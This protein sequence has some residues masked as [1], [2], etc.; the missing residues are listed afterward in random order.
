MLG[1]EL[2]EI[3]TFTI[4][5]SRPPGWE[6][7]A[8]NKS[9]RKALDKCHRI[10]SIVN[11]MDTKSQ[12]LLDFLMDILVEHRLVL[13]ISDIADILEDAVQSTVLRF[14]ADVG[15]KPTFNWRRRLVSYPC[16]FAQ[17]RKQVQLS[18][19][20]VLYSVYRGYGLYIALSH[21]NQSKDPTLIPLILIISLHDSPHSPTSSLPHFPTPPLPHS[22]TPPLLHSSTPGFPSSRHNLCTEAL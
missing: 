17:Y 2:K 21:S 20:L 14:N 9:I 10:R 19:C 3:K 6:D 5:K 22:P 13:T 15:D 4:V 16:G 18:L 1:I 7:L 11:I 12:R 8:I